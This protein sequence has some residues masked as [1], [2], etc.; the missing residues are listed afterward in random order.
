MILECSGRIMAIALAMRY[1]I[2][3]RRAGCYEDCHVHIAEYPD[4][5]GDSQLKIIHGSD[6]LEVVNDK[7]AAKKYMAWA[8]KLHGLDTED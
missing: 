5:V 6:I 7:H 1:E 3:Y 8:R 4:E 2:T